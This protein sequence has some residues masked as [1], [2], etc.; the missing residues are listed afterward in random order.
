MLVHQ[1]FERVVNAFDNE[2]KERF[3]EPVWFMLQKGYASSGGFKSSPNIQHLINDTGLW[4]IVFRDGRITAVTLYKDMY[5][6]KAIAGATDTSVQGRKDFS[7]L[8][9]DDFRLGRAWTEA[10]GV[11]E[12]LLQKM[13][14]KP[15]PAKFARI[16]TGKNIIEINPDGIH[17][18][19]MIGGEPHEKAIY[20][21]VNLSGHE[22]QRLLDQGIQMHEI[23]T[24][25]N[26]RS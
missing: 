7:M 19:R 14:A 23:P 5:G 25:D 16:L 11:P 3:A 10:S 24:S 13:G 20:G 17:Y 2:T 1:L 15:I 12:R 18:T 26:L 8:N 9:R 21:M 4:K 22:V 6:R